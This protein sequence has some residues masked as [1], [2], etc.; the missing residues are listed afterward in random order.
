M[1][2]GLKIR[3]SV[4]CPSE[5]DKVIMIEKFRDDDDS[6]PMGMAVRQYAEQVIKRGLREHVWLLRQITLTAGIAM[7]AVAAATAM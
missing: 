7:A 3:A 1:A 4:W 6:R 5:K 2:R